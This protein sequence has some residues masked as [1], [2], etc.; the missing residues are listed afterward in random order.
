M[1]PRHG[2]AG[3]GNSARA[4]AVSLLLAGSMALGGCSLLPDGNQ[5]DAPAPA[6][7]TTESAVAEPEAPKTPQAP[8]TPEPPKTPAQEFSAKLN[9]SL[10]NLAGTTKTPNREQMIG[11]MV[12]AGAD[13][14]K[15][16]V[17]IDIT[18]TGLAVDAIEAATPVENDCVVG[19]VRGGSVAVMVLP[20]LASGRCFVGD[21]H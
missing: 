18:P 20:V 11:A 9:D 5:E 19:Q 10:K 12:E 17:S 16:E 7:A 14:Q 21:V 6:T 3:F 1:T 15:I 8:K 13:S 2:L 4:I